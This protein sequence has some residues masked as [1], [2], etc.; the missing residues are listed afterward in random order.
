MS[1][2]CLHE[3]FLIFTFDIKKEKSSIN[4][5]TFIVFS[6]THMH[7]LYIYLSLSLSLYIY[8]YIYMYTSIYKGRIEVT[9]FHLSL[10][11]HTTVIKDGDSNNDDDDDG[12]RGLC[13]HNP[14]RRSPKCFEEAAQL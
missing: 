6:K 10:K 3:I 14:I 11:V 1:V 13:F 4:L 5:N 12:S 8:I 9:R 7:T 2:D